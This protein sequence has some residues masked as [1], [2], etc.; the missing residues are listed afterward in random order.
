MVLAAFTSL[1]P[2]SKAIRLFTACRRFAE[3]AP[4]SSDAP[5]TGTVDAKVDCPVQKR[6]QPEVAVIGVK[7]EPWLPPLA[8]G[9]FAMR[10]SARPP[11][12][13]EALPFGMALCHWFTW[14]ECEKSCAGRIAML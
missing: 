6:P 13:V 2:L 3:L 14:S 10:S 9:V 1:R 12:P 7:L 11:Q 4:I 5:P 8:N